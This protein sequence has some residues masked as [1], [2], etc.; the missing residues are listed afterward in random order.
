MPWRIY[1]HCREG[2]L[3]EFVGDTSFYNW[4]VKVTQ[5]CPTL[6]RLC[7]ASGTLQVRILEWVAAPFSRESSHPRDRT[8]VSCIPGRFFNQLSHWGSPRI[9]GWVAYPIFQGLFLTQESNRGLLHCM[10]ILYQL[11]YQESLEAMTNGF[12]LFQKFFI[13][14][15]FVSFMLYCVWILIQISMK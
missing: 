6:L 5:S 13:D 12:S 14:Q 7:I 15:D 10:R 3:T 9:L 1:S 11:R 8:Q 2:L 4:W